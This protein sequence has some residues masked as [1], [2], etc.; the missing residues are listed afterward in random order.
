MGSIKLARNQGMVAAYLN[1][2]AVIIAFVVAL[3][4]TG[5]VI[6][7][8]SPVYYLE[9]CRDGGKLCNCTW[10]NFYDCAYAATGIPRV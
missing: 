8:Y 4:V 7:L 6:G 2:F 1:F 3:L 10:T 5:L 9:Q